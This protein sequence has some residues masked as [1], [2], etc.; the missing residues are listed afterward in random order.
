MLTR[1]L[2]RARHGKSL[3]ALGAFAA[4]VTT[5]AVVNPERFWNSLNPLHLNAVAFVA[6]F[7]GKCV[8]LAAIDAVVDAFLRR[9]YASAPLPYRKN[10]GAVGLAQLEWIDYLYLAI[11]SVVEFVFSAHVLR[12]VL[13]ADPA[14]I[15]WRPSD[16]G[17]FNTVPALYLVFALDD[18]F[19]APAHRLMH[20]PALYPYVHKH[21]HRQNLPTRGYLDAGNEHPIE[22]VLGLTC[23]WA[24]LRVVAKLVGLHVVTILLHFLLYATLALLNHTNF[25]VQFDVFGFEYSVRSHEMHHRFPQTNLAQYFMLW[26][27]LMGTYRPYHDGLSSSKDPSSRTPSAPLSQVSQVSQVSQAQ[28]ATTKRD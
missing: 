21:H 15:A 1:V 4:A 8:S 2:G 5:V 11:N 12:L 9:Q 14:D 22:Q 13:E 16:L 17:L 26:D 28:A 24:T 25:D 7:A 20:L 18:F 19:Y 27:K 10:T 3:F 23:L 6:L